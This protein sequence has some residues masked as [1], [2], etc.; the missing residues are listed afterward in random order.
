MPP[1]FNAFQD[2]GYLLC[3]RLRCVGLIFQDTSSL[4]ITDQLTRKTITPYLL[5]VARN[6]SPDIKH[7]QPIHG[8]NSG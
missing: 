3:I 4:A 6:A 2:D 8:G 5:L 7:K 1:Q